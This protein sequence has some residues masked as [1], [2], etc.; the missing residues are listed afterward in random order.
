MLATLTNPTTTP[1]PLQLHIDGLPTAPEAE[2]A[3][4]LLSL[5]GWLNEKRAAVGAA[6]AQQGEQQAEQQAQQQ[7]AQQAQ[8]PQQE[9]HQAQGQLQEQRQQQQQAQQLP[10]LQEGQEPEQQQQQQPSTEQDAAALKQE[11]GAAPEMGPQ[12]EQ[13]A[14]GE[15]VAAEAAPPLTEP[16]LPPLN[17]PFRQALLLACTAVGCAES[18]GFRPCARHMRLPAVIPRAWA[19]HLGSTSAAP[20]RAMLA[21]RLASLSLCPFNAPPLCSFYAGHRCLEQLEQ[22]PEGAAVVNY[23]SGRLGSA[24]RSTHACGRRLHCLRSHRCADAAHHSHPAARPG[25][26]SADFLLHPLLLHLAALS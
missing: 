5:W 19:S 20:V 12:P 6:P 10:V 2:V 14:S 17:Y 8:Q 26:V 11:D 1:F 22:L 25:I 9:Q 24:T 21:R 13:P 4:D 7:Q 23:V 16:P 15:A 3:R 18:L